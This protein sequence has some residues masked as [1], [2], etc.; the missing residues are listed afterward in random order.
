MSERAGYDPMDLEVTY[1]PFCDYLRELGFNLREMSTGMDSVAWMEDPDAGDRV[2]PF[3]MGIE[4][5]GVKVAKVANMDQKEKIFESVR[6]RMEY[7]KKGAV[8]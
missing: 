2:P 6:R 8:E 3:F 7:F 1:D 4:V 5:D